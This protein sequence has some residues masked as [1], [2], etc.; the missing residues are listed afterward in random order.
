MPARTT[1]RKRRKAPAQPA[2]AAPAPRP[3]QAA[4]QREYVGLRIFLSDDI[5]FR[6]G[7]ATFDLP[8]TRDG[9]MERLWADFVKTGVLLTALDVREE[10]GSLLRRVQDHLAAAPTPEGWK[11][12]VAVINL[13]DRLTYSDVPIKGGFS[14][15][16]DLAFLEDANFHRDAF[17]TTDN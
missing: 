2:K 11:R 15:A 14:G 5:G 9:L 6:F 3:K 10:G 1:N 16:R 13:E 12:A 7:I 8:A 17:L 4:A